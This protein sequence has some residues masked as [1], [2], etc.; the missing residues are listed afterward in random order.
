MILDKNAYIYL[1]EFLPKYSSFFRNL[2]CPED[3]IEKMLEGKIKLVEQQ[4]DTLKKEQ[5]SSNQM[6]DSMLKS[7]GEKKQNRKRKYRK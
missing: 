1:A 7:I 4:R 6:F 5:N 3:L 2:I